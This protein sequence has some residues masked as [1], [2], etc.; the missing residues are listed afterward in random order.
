MPANE[1]MC[2]TCRSAISRSD[3]RYRVSEPGQPNRSLCSACVTRYGV[4]QY[5]KAVIVLP[6]DLSVMQQSL[7]CSCSN[8][9]IAD[10]PLEIA[11]RE[12][13]ALARRMLKEVPLRHDA[14][15]TTGA[16]IRAILW[17]YWRSPKSGWT[18][19]G[20]TG[21]SP[22]PPSRTKPS[23]T[24][25]IRRTTTS[26]TTAPGTPGR[27]G[28]NGRPPHHTQT[29]RRR[30]PAASSNRTSTVPSPWLGSCLA[31][32]PTPAPEHKGAL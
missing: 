24:P 31:S 16:R 25:G 28:P 9:R 11:E 19:A 10:A 5:R 21:K 6:D 2:H 32:R 13:T 7:F 26:K 20:P 18:C 12:A 30:A 1:R 14:G 17:P 3:F 4:R 22:M 29:L 27:V 15:D 23:K 8:C